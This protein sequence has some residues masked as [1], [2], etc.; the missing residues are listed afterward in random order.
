VQEQYHDGN[1]TLKGKAHPRTD[2]EGPEEEYR[3][4]STHSLTSALD[5]VGWSGHAPAALLLERNSVPIVQKAG[6]APESF[7]TGSANLAPTRIRSLHRPACNESLDR[8]RY[9][10]PLAGLEVDVTATGPYSW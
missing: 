3:Y 2:H 10:G 7:W 6:W 1:W 5:K 9:S 8:L 4:S